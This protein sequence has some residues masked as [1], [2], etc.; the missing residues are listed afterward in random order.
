MSVLLCVHSKYDVFPFSLLSFLYQGNTL[1]LT[2][3]IVSLVEFQTARK[4]T[5]C[6]SILAGHLD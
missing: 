3:A 1:S 6:P 4:M 2:I 5:S